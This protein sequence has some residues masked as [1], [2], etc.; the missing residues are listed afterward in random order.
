VSEFWYRERES[1][2][3]AWGN[4]RVTSSV[5]VFELANGIAVYLE[6]KPVT[7]A[8]SRIMIGARKSVDKPTRFLL[9]RFLNRCSRFT[10][11]LHVVLLG[12][13]LS[14]IEA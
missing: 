5:I 10:R 12:G 8:E 2:M 3:Q 4:V 1:R 14:R 13:I 7:S 6:S 9:V 11:A